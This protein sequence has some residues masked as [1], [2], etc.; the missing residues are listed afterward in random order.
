MKKALFILL[1]SLF[2]KFAA[3]GQSPEAR[4]FDEYGNSISCE[5]YLSRADA[6]KIEQANNPNSRIY[7]IVYEGKERKRDYN[8]KNVTFKSV[9]PQYGQAAATIRTM[10]KRL[11]LNKVPIQNYIFV[12]GGFREQFGV[13][14]WLVPSGAGLPKP[15]PTLEKMKY[16][17]GKPKGFCLDCC[18]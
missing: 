9:L 15:T 1:I 18:G 16:R 14:I 17:K 12:N 13:E 10:Q 5:E 2:V 8:S 6:M 3:F 4:L 7:V 11:K